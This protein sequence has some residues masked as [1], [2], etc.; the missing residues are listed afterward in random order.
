MAQAVTAL[1]FGYACEI[2]LM[3][4]GS[5]MS[6]KGY[7]DGL[8]SEAFDPL[9]LL[10]DSFR[11]MGGKLYVCDP[12]IDALGVKKEDCIEVDGYINAAKL[13]ESATKASVVF[14]Y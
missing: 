11:E 1:A 9:S 3:D 4:K 7:L 13:L 6:I 10:L 5:R 2:Y 14:T 12:S 8:K